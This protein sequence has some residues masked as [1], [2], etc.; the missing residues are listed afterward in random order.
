MEK[1]ITKKSKSTRAWFPMKTKI[2]SASPIIFCIR[3]PD[4]LLYLTFYE[5]SGHFPRMC[6]KQRTTNVTYFNN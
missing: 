3:V 6:D 5:N 4:W 1:K 2:S